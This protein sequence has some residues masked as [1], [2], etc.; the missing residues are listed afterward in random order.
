LS[1]RFYLTEKNADILFIPRA[2]SKNTLD[3]WVAGGVSASVVSG[4]FTASSNRVGHAFGGRGF[5]TSPDGV[6]LGVT[7]DEKPFLTV[8]LDI[9]EAKKAKSTYPRYIQD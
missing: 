9:N 3:K 4:C 1:H 8:E 6:V 7:T 5:I 2:T